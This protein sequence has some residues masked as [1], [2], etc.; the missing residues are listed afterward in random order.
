M[1]KSLLVFSAILLST[2]VVFAKKID[3]DTPVKWNSKVIT[4]ALTLAGL[5]DSDAA[6]YDIKITRQRIL[7]DL[8]ER[9]SFSLHTATTVCMNKCNMSDFLRNGLG[10]SHQKC[11]ALCTSFASNI[12][13][14]NNKL[15]TKI[16]S[17]NSTNFAFESLQ[18]KPLEVCRSIVGNA[19]ASGMSFPMLCGGNCKRFGND[20]LMVTDLQKTVNYKVN[21]F[22]DGVKKAVEYF[23]V[24]SSDRQA[25]DVSSLNESARM[26]KL[27]EAQT[28]PASD[29][30]KGK[31]DQEKENTKR[32]YEARIAPLKKQ[33]AEEV[34][35]IGYCKVGTLLKLRGDCKK[36]ARKFAQECRCKIKG[37][38][39]RKELERSTSRYITTECYMGDPDYQES[40]SMFYA[41]TPHEY[42]PTF[43]DCM[44]TFNEKHCSSSIKNLWPASKDDLKYESNATTASS[45]NCQS[46]YGE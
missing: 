29:Y 39:D 23:Y 36:Q 27:H 30:L 19:K 6:H 15:A 17:A 42:V 31:S 40:E 22:C 43:E 34:E 46:F 11:P 12:I 10:Q 33:Y 41:F 13:K 8:L 45:Y 5:V 1:K 32:D 9:E 25:E 28:K 7:A 3:F 35:K 4:S 2:T 44:A 24:F 37:Y 38:T 20:I 18:G 16:P 14:E 26:V 21:D